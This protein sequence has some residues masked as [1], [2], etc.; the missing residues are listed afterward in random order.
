MFSGEAGAA[1]RRESKQE[2]EAHVF[3][4]WGASCDGRVGKA[5][6]TEPRSGA[7]R[8]TLT[9]AERRNEMKIDTQR[10]P[11]FR[12]GT[13]RLVYRHGTNRCPVCPGG[14]TRT[15]GN[16]VTFEPGAR[17]AWH[18]H[19]LGQ[20][21]DR[22]L[23]SRP[24]AAPRRADRDIRPGDVVW[25]EPGEKHWHGASPTSAM[26]HIAIQEACSTGRRWTGSSTSA[27]RNTWARAARPRRGTSNL[28][29]SIINPVPWMSSLQ[30]FDSVGL[31]PSQYDRADDRT[32]SRSR[33]ARRKGGWG[34][35]TAP[36]TRS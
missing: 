14:G 31:Q 8:P 33:Q 34:R 25:F 32:L 3:V 9:L 36:P 2:G 16:S 28:V 26:S 27:R 23:R 5:P 4:P 10:C 35:S 12:A 22:D 17:T 18:T 13:G 24:G 19:P 30:A 7:A 29:P 21:L 20:A 11:C 15:A 1:G 6:I